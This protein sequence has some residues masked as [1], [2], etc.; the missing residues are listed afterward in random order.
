MSLITRCPACM[1]LFKVVQDQLRISDGWV[2]CGQCDEVFDASLHLQSEVAAVSAPGV[3]LDLSADWTAQS[4]VLLT[5]PPAMSGAMTDAALLD[6]TPLAL[7]DGSGDATPDPLTDS[8]GVLVK[9]AASSD[10]AGAMDSEP[11]PAPALGLESVSFLRDVQAEPAARKP[12]QRISGWLLVF[13]LLLGLAGQG[14]VHE[15]DRL[16]AAEPD[17][18]PVLEALCIPLN[19]VLSPLRQIESIVIDSASFTKVRGNA[20]RLNFMVKNTAAIAL[21]LPAI[22]VT[23]TNSSEQTVVRRVFLPAELGANMAALAPGAEWPASA[24][25]A[26]KLAGSADQVAGYRVFAFYP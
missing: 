24:A 19:C 4:N 15:R 8:W 14:L 12:W 5:E 3:D 13:A 23:L 22:E 21:A 7:E 16:L 11:E 25:V 18:K 26:L 6:R 9:D 20:Y 10:M 1:T 17:L 2:R